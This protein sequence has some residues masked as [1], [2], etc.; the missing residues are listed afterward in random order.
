MKTDIT[1]HIWKT[2]GKSFTVE[3]HNFKRNDHKNKWNVYAYLY[4]KHRL[5]DAITNESLFDY[6]VSLPLHCGASYHVWHYDK[7]GKVLSKQIGSDYMYLHDCFEHCKT[8]KQAYEVFADADK[9]I[10]FLKENE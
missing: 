10:E 7:H 6:G 2:E 3:V 1:K 9:L 5:F 8:P 4:P